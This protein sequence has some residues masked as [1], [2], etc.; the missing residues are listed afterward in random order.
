LAKDTQIAP[1][2]GTSLVSGSLLQRAADETGTDEMTVGQ[3]GLN[4]EMSTDDL[5]QLARLVYPFVKR[6]LAIE[7]ERWPRR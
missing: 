4:E 7:R 6:L 3:I 5:S 1:L 2:S